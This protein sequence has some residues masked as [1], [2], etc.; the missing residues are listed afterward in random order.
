MDTKN[1][2]L[3]DVMFTFVFFFS[4]S[5]QTE[6]NNELKERLTRR[7]ITDSLIRLLVQE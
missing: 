4:E 5:K 1:C 2:R 6:T 7:I 3:C